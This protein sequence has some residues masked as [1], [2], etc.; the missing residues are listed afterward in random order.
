M[1]ETMFST[2]PNPSLIIE[3]NHAAAYPQGINSKNKL[4]V[5]PGKNRNTDF[6]VVSGLLPYL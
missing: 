5:F 6:D 3:K 2:H 1:F 4:I